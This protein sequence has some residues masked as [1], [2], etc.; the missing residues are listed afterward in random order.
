[1]KEK[2]NVLV[3]QLCP[4]LC[5]PMDCSLPGSLF[6]QFSRQEYRS[7]LP[8]PSPDLPN[9][10]T[11]PGSPVLQTDPLLSEPQGKPMIHSMNLF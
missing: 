11:E 8:C 5:D 4:T 6:M 3:I 10:R 7:G 2:V 9:P 1:M